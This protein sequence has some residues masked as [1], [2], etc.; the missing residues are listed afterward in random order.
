MKII[1]SCST[2][3]GK[4]LCELLKDFYYG[5]DVYSVRIYETDDYINYKETHRSYHTGNIVKARTLYKKYKNRWLR[6]KK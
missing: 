5:S 2:T 4:I 1:E 3:D 6:N